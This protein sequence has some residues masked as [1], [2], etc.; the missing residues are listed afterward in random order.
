MSDT[1]S[2][3]MLVNVLGIPGILLCIYFGNEIFLGFI[4][5]VSI[6]AMMEYF[7]LS[8]QKSISPQYVIS[9]L[10][11]FIILMFYYV[12]DLSQIYTIPLGQFFVLIVGIT[13]I[14]ELF[15]NKPNPSLNIAVSLFG[16]FY[17]P[18]LLGALIGIREF[19]PLQSDLN[20][21]LTFSLFIA[22]WLCDSAA[23]TFGK[24]WGKKKIL[25]RV[26]PKKTV[27]GAVSGLITA[28]MVYL[29]FIKFRFIVSSDPTFSISYSDAVMMGI[30]V[31]V[32]GQMGDFIESMFKR[33]VCV[34]D[35]SRIL[36]GHGGV[37][38]RFDSLLIASPLIYLYLKFII[39]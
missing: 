21:K 28:I 2:S 17:I 7:K 22:V 29:A 36:G 13:L 39:D 32:F 15:R 1:L 5:V 20:M 8:E 4:F 16:I 23:Y 30:I 33:E 37:L 14:T 19:F 24:L 25:E 12:S 31:G 18:L 34:K 27:V 38:D 10:S 35:T 3:R 11:A 26:S 6:L 9:C